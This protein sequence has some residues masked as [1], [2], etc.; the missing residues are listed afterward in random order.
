MACYVGEAAVTVLVLA[1]EFPAPLTAKTVNG[2]ESV[3]VEIAAKSRISKIGAPSGVKVP[4][5]TLC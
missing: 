3:P 2:N 5:F 1:L 4:V